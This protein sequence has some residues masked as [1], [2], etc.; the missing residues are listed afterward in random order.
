[1]FNLHSW[2]CR[3]VCTVLDLI[4]EDG[5]LQVTT[6]FVSRQREFIKNSVN[7]WVSE[8][9]AWSNLSSF[10]RSCATRSKDKNIFAKFEWIWIF[11]SAQIAVAVVR[12]IWQFE[13]FWRLTDRNLIPRKRDKLYWFFHFRSDHPHYATAYPTHLET[14]PRVLYLQVE[15]V[16]AFLGSSGRAHAHIFSNT[17]QKNIA[18][19]KENLWENQI[20]SRLYISL[21][22]VSFYN[23]SVHNCK[24]LNTVYF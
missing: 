21:H 6:A 22:H 16:V 8:K 1:V 19:N 3:S 9:K 15:E 18:I 23:I 20:F 13:V 14:T 17:F 5:R 11:A 2:K 24:Y 10:E 12:E 4:T 7:E